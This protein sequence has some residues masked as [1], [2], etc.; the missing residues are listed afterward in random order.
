M[1]YLFFFSWRF[2]S[3]LHPHILGVSCFHTGPKKNNDAA[4]SLSTI[5]PFCTAQIPLAPTSLVMMFAKRSNDLMNA[6][7]S[8]NQRNMKGKST[9]GVV[10]SQ[11]FNYLSGEGVFTCLSKQFWPPPLSQRTAALNEPR[12]SASS[13]VM[14]QRRS[15]AA[16]RVFPAILRVGG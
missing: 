7:I 12:V 14:V 1:L 3:F 6:P 10:V 9:V 8:G 11:I 16:L 15:T 2:S 4:T 5:V 13:P